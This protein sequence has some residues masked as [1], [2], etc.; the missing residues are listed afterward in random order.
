[1]ALDGGMAPMQD[2]QR[3]AKRTHARAMGKAPSGPAGYQGLCR[4]FCS[5]GRG[6]HL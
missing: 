5:G 1:V 3:Q 6:I 2:G 4:K